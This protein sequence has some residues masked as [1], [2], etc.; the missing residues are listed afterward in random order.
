[1]NNNRSD[2]EAAYTSTA[3]DLKEATKAMTETVQ[4]IMSITFLACKY[5]TKTHPRGRFHCPAYRDICTFCRK[6]NHTA[7]ACQTRIAQTIKCANI[8]STEEATEK[9]KE[10]IE[11]VKKSTQHIRAETGKS[12]A[13]VT[14]P[15]SGNMIN[16]S[17][18]NIN[19][20]ALADSGA[21]VCCVSQD[22]VNRIQPY[23]PQPYKK[24][25]YQ[26]MSGFCGESH[27]VLGMVDLKITIGEN[28][29]T[30]S[31]HVL[32]RL[33]YPMLIG[34]DFFTTHGAV[35]DFDE[36]VITFKQPNVPSIKITNDVDNAFLRC[37]DRVNIPPNHEMLVPV[38]VP[39]TNQILLIE[40][41][42]A[43]KEIP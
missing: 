7:K 3:D 19:T 16:V 14:I 21:D 10:H 43:L 36:K 37:K 11:Y 29:A 15:M 38:R 35:L 18:M 41:I 8:L 9:K 32:P 5:C 39:L 13:S 6:P 26:A 24:S 17:V 27:N 40:D 12:I 25:P 28:T 22:V 42:P 31:F 33:Q 34:K 4:A 30:R 1:M 20:K 23:V 2:N